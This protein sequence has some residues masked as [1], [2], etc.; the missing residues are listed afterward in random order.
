MVVSCKLNFR[1]VESQMH[2]LTHAKPYF[3]HLASKL[4]KMK[5]VLMTEKGCWASECFTRIIY[6]LFKHKL[7]MYLQSHPELSL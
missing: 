3:I 5:N 1:M 4:A 6:L 7:M 2:I